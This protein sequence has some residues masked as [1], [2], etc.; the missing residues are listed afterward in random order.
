MR[1]TLAVALALFMFASFTPASTFAGSENGAQSGD[2]DGTGPDRD[3][4]GSCQFVIDGAPIVAGKMT[5]DQDG[6]GPDRDQDRDTLQDGSCQFATDDASLLA[7][8]RKGKRTGP[9][10]GSGPRRD[11]SCLNV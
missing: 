3:R 11:G 6:T 9:R 8:N 1:K 7:A 5:G 10:D 4:D 2:Q